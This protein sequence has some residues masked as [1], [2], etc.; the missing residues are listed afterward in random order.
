[1]LHRLF[2]LVRMVFAVM[3][4]LKLLM[5]EWL[6]TEMVFNEPSRPAPSSHPLWIGA[7]KAGDGC[8]VLM[9][10]DLTG[11]IAHVSLQCLYKAVSL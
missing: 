11:Q 3:A 2:V 6:S 4:L 7:V 9:Y 1:V 8:A 10:I 5:T